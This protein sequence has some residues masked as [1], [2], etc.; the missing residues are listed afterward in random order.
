M[1]IISI[2]T[3]RN[4]FCAART[5]NTKSMVGLKCGTIAADVL[6][7]FLAGKH[8]ANPLNTSTANLKLQLLCLHNAHQFK[9]LLHLLSFGRNLEEGL[10][11]PNLGG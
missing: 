5:V 1:H 11:I 3:E 9:V 7:K 2:L 8:N 6:D 4:F 10:G